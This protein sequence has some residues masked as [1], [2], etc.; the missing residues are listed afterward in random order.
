MGIASTFLVATELL[1]GGVQINWRYRRQFNELE[2]EATKQVRFI[3]GVA[4]EAVLNL[5]FLTLETLIRQ[6]SE[7]DEIAY[8]VVLNS[9]QQPLTQFI[10]RSSPSADDRSPSAN[11]SQIPLLDAI[12]QIRA[13]PTIREIRAPIVSNNNYLG[14]VWLGYSTQNLRR[15]MYRTAWMISVASVLVSLLL[16]SLTLIL[17]EWQVRRPLQEL[18]DASQAL[19]NGDLNRRVVSN[20]HEDEI[21]QLSQALNT[22]ATQ[23]QQTLEGL[24]ETADA[25]KQQLIATAAAETKLKIEVEERRQA[26]QELE[27]L[28]GHLEESNRELQDF[29]YVSSH[30][31]QEPLRKI[32][33]FG[34]RLKSTCQDSLNERGLDY[35][36]R[37]LN[38][39][40][41][42]QILIDDLLAFSRVTTKA[43]PFTSVD[44]PQ[45]LEGVLSD[46]EIRIEETGAVLE[47]DPLPTVE[48]DALQMRQILQNLLSNALKFQR[49]GIPP[50][51]QI[52]SRIYQQQDRDYLE[53]RVIDN[54][55]GFEQKYADRIFRIFERLHGRKVYQGSGIGLAICRKIAARHGG[56]LTAESTP[57]QG[58]TFILTLPVCQPKGAHYDQ[59]G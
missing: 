18:T 33:A 51:I 32:Q 11:K 9:Q 40:S 59:Q 22:M 19:A 8:I 3:A 27:R 52:R 49:E 15:E 5:D 12:A 56:M 2:N 46:L 31:L 30:D 42:A 54:G 10:E 4:P 53:L 45:V 55:I 44:L 26:M 36:E 28:T 7:D 57:E 17:F 41:R 13:Q 43:K 29:A 20:S 58:A 34:D 35:L 24:Q 39:A 16:A 25:L 38:A 1:F 47:I 14:E 23:L 37:M 50:T 21:G 6:A 48:A